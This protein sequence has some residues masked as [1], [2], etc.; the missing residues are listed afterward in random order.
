MSYSSFDAASRGAPAATITNEDAPLLIKPASH[1]A[2]IE[3]ATCSTHMSSSV[4]QRDLF[5]PPYDKICGCGGRSFCQSYF[6]IV[7]V[8]AGCALGFSSS[9]LLSSRYWKSPTGLAQL[10]CSHEKPVSKNLATVPK[11]L[12]PSADGSHRLA[13]LK[14]EM[15]SGEADVD[16]LSSLDG[17]SLAS[18][19]ILSTSRSTASSSASPNVYLNHQEAYDMLLNGPNQGVGLLGLSASLSEYSAHYF[20]LN[21]GMDVQVN[22][23]YC[24]AASVS[25]ILNSLRFMHPRSEV[26]VDIPT[27]SSYDPYSY[28]TQFDLFG[29]CTSNNVVDEAGSNAFDGWGS[30][31]ILSF[32][33]G[34]TLEQ[35]ASLL[36]CH[37][38]ENAGWT[39]TV[40]HLDETHLTLSKM[41]YDMM[42]AL[43]DASSRIVVNYHRAAA[44]QVGG[45]HFSPIGAYD[46]AS[47]S[48][49]ILDVARY[50]Y[51]PMWISADRLYEAMNTQDN[52]GD[53]DYP[54]AQTKLN[55]RLRKAKSDD[56]EARAALGCKQTPRGY[57]IARRS[58]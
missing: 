9:F 15:L 45:G 29:D 55:E 56:E 26:G 41:R 42:Q 20:L 11:S 1:E 35:T 3:E 44:G 58:G 46:A 51:P 23:A 52:C 54:A 17:M 21:S 43:S 18:L 34:L 5:D 6:L 19:P 33:Y 4:S 13:D 8:F 48:F 31:G 30:D 57:I 53:W 37:L 39:V 47:D 28:A 50:K 16:S 32:P 38:D 12:F 40:T 36:M 2:L 49:L 10:G 14:L 22:Q 24:A 27:D 7:A 25:A